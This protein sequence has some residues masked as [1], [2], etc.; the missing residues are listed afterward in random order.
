M[1]ASSFSSVIYHLLT[2]QIKQVDT[3]PLLT[4]KKNIMDLISGFR[5]RLIAGSRLTGGLSN[6]GASDNF[7]EFYSDEGQATDPNMGGPPAPIII[8][9]PCMLKA[10]EEEETKIKREEEEAGINEDGYVCEQCRVGNDDMTQETSEVLQEI[11]AIDRK[12]F[13]TVEDDYIF[14]TMSDEYNS[15]I[16]HVHNNVLKDKKL[17]KWTKAGVRRHITKHSRSNPHRVMWKRMLHI[18]RTLDFIENNG[19]YDREYEKQAD[20]TEV[21]TGDIEQINP[22]NHK[23]WA[24]LVKTQ[25]EL[26]KL[27]LSFR[28]Q[29][30]KD[31]I[32]QSGSSSS[33]RRQDRNYSVS[34]HR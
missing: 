20:G 19:Y 26:L 10:Q 21:P 1:T 32:G 2:K 14:Q 7:V 16:Y 33:N 27:D 34:G 29:E 13:L 3:V 31:A 25:T 5:D 30:V 9:K 12:L 23:I 11:Y 18:E 15:T 22:R 8:R 17:K 6:V 4:A 28:Q 24:S